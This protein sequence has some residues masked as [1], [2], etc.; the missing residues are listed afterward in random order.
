MEGEQRVQDAKAHPRKARGATTPSKRQP[1]DAPNSST[2]ICLKH[3]NFLKDVSTSC[4]HEALLHFGV[5]NTPSFISTYPCPTE[6][7]ME[8]FE[9]GL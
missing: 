1:K 7:K 3:F 9:R 6:D 2:S 8:D 4:L 5:F